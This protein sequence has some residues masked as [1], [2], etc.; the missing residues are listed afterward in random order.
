M[1]CARSQS[2]DL[3]R[4]E[5]GINEPASTVEFLTSKLGN[6]PKSACQNSACKGMQV[7]RISNVCKPG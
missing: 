6:L 5:G 1:T 4:T 3:T 2:F 7:I